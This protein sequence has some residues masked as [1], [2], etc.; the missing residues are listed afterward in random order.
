[1]SSLVSTITAFHWKFVRAPIYSLL[2]TPNCRNM[3]RSR[4]AAAILSPNERQNLLFKETMYDLVSE[5]GQALTGGRFLM[6][7]GSRYAMYVFMID[8]HQQWLDIFRNTPD[9]AARDIKAFL[10]F[11]PNYRVSCVV[12]G[13]CQDGISCHAVSLTIRKCFNEFVCD[14]YETNGTSASPIQAAM[15]LMSALGVTSNT[16]AILYPT[17]NYYG[18]CLPRAIELCLQRLANLP[19]AT[20][21]DEQ[22]S[23]YVFG[24]DFGTSE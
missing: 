8:D 6:V 24:R 4:S 17:R 19:I 10:Q 11:N 12:G 7:P 18:Y 21:C 14:Y 23:T 16:T 9:G 13:L 20:N 15:D 22:P 2:A 3:T 5:S 1:M